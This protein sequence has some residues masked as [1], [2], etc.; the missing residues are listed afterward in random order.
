MENSGVKGLPVVG[1]TPTQS[2]ENIALVN[3]GKELEE[4]VRRWFDKIGERPMSCNMRLLAMARS[5][6]EKGMM[7]AYK[8]VFQPGDGRIALPEDGDGDAA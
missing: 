3:E 5:E 2:T 4:R 7:L 1:Y 8:A 6:C